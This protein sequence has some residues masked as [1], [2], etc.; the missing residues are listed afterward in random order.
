MR[1]DKQTDRQTYKHVTAILHT[2]KGGE[3]IM[4]SSCLTMVKTSP[5]LMANLLAANAYEVFFA[6]KLMNFTPYLII[7]SLISGAL[8]KRGL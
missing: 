7:T 4:S 1:A 8:Q 2:P 3:V 5:L 6:I